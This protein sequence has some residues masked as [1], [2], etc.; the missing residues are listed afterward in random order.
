MG[1]HFT[2]T[3]YGCAEYLCHIGLAPGELEYRRRY[4]KI[5][6]VQRATA[7][8]FN[9]PLFEMRSE[10]RSRE[11]V[12]PRQVAMYLC[13]ELTNRSYIIIGREFGRRDHTTVI[14]ACRQ[15]EKLMPIEPLLSASVKSI[16]A[17]LRA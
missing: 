15:I 5:G 10:R 14:H 2:I 1:H 9:L 6:E 17:E 8:Y 12:R 11:V 7:D 4:L 3:T 16:R 13:R